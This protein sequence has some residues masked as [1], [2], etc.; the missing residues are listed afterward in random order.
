MKEKF[1]IIFRAKQK[2][3]LEFISGT[4][5]LVQ[6]FCLYVECVLIP[7]LVQTECSLVGNYL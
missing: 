2:N 1:H 3:P 4:L 6:D 5:K 7:I